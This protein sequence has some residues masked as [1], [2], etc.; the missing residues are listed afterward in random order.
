M[1]V[2]LFE[3]APRLGGRASSFMDQD[4]GEWLD[5]GQHLFLGAYRESL[6]LLTDL[7]TRDFV[8][9]QRP[10]CVPYLMDDGRLE[11]L[12]ASALPGPLSLGVGLARFSALPGAAGA[13]LKLGLRG[14]PALASAFLG[15]LPKASDKASVADWLRDCGQDSGIIALLWEPMVLAALNARPEEARLREFLAVLGGGFLRGGFSAALGMATAPLAKLL[16][17][18]PALLKEQGS[19]ALLGAAVE[20]IEALPGGGWRAHRTGGASMDSPRVVLALPARRAVRVLGP[21][22]AARLDLEGQAARPDSAIVSVWLWSAE[23]LLPKGLQA[24]GPQAGRPPRFH[25]GFSRAVEGGWRTCAVSSAAAELA[26]AE[27]QDILAG[28]AAFLASRGRPYTWA[29][30]RVVK[31]RSATPIFAPGSPPR[32]AQ[33]TAVKGLALAGDWTETGLPATI[34]GAVRSGR[35]AVEALSFDKR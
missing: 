21:E 20:R 8:E 11:T 18:L 32:L 7:G 31:E 30:A 4:S 1:R 34:E 12:Q 16:N 19:E 6:S 29:R 35:L 28:L 2:A 23:A 22:L 33:A 26:A 25:W 14:G 9:F 10:L 13:L 3:A 15:H 24:F 27:S 5:H 17:P